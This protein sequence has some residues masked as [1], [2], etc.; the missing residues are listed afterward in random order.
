MFKHLAALFIICFL[1]LVEWDVSSAPFLFLVLI[2]YQVVSIFSHYLG[3]W[4]SLAL[5]RLVF[6][7]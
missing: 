6:L 7:V 1:L 5:C 4:C 3:G 2:P